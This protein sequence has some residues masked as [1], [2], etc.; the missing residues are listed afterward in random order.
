MR[1][2][3]KRGQRMDTQRSQC[4]FHLDLAHEVIA[5]D[6]IEDANH[7]SDWDNDQWT[8]TGIAGDSELDGRRV[9][10]GY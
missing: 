9:N 10:L 2:E 5:I 1:M 3:E 6:G 8:I 4:W 7:A